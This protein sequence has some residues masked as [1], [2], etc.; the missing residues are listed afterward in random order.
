[1]DWSDHICKIL[2]DFQFG[3]F[4]QSLVINYAI[5]ISETVVYGNKQSCWLKNKTF[6]RNR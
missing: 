1:M 6:I 5:L 4:L 3:V 2:V